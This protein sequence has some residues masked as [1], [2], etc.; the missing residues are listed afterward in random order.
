GSLVAIS[1]A[2]H[3]SAVPGVPRRFAL[4]GE[5]AFARALS[6]E[7]GRRVQAGEVTDRGPLAGGYRAM[8]AAGAS[9]LEPCRVKPVLA[10]A[11]GRRGEE[12]IAAYFVEILREDAGRAVGAD[13]LIHGTTGAVLRRRDLDHHAAFQYR[14]WADPVDGR[15]HDGPLED[16]TPHPTG[17]PDHIEL[18]GTAPSLVTMEGFNAFGDPWLPDDATVSTGNNVDAY[19]DRQSP[20]GFGAGD[21]RAEVTAPGVFDRAYDLTLGPLASPE[22]ARASVAH[23]FY[24]NN[25]L[26]D[27][28][29][30]SGF[31][32]AAG[33]AQMNNYGRGGLDGDPLLAEAQDNA[34]GGSRDNAN[35][36]TPSDGVSPRM[37]MYLWSADDPRS[38]TFDPPVQ[39]VSTGTAEFGPQT[40]DVSGPLLVTTPADGCAPVGDVSGGVALIDRGTCTFESKVMAAE[41]AGAVG[42]LIAN[43]VAGSAPGMADGEPGDPSIPVLSIS[44]EAGEAL[45]AALEDGAITARMQRAAGVER[46]SSLD[47]TIIA[48]EWGHYLHHRLQNCGT[49]MCGALS[50]G[51]GDFVALHTVVREGDDPGGVYAMS[52]YAGQ[53]SDDAAYFGIRRAPYTRDTSKNGFT[54]RHIARGEPL[55]QHPLY[56]L[57][58][59]N[60]EV[61]N[62]GEVWA[63]MLFEAYQALLDQTRGGAPRYSFDE[64]RRRMSDYVVAGLSLAPADSTFVEARD[65]ILAAAAASDPDD[66]VA[67]AAG[68]ATRGAGS[69]AVSP[70]RSSTDFVGVVE[71][72]AVSPRLALGEITLEVVGDVCDGDGLLDGEE[73]GVVRVV[74]GN[75]G[76]APLT[77]AA[78]EVATTTPGVSFPDGTTHPVPAIDPLSTATVDIPIAL[79]ATTGIADAEISVDVSAPDTCEES[80]GGELAVRV[81]YDVVPASS[82]TDDVEADVSV[83]TRAGNAA[84]LVWA[85]APL[86]QGNRAWHGADATSITDTQLVSPPFTVASSGPLEI[87]FRHRH[88]FET[89]SG[90]FW[91]GAVIEITSDGGATWEDVTAYGA[92]PPYGG[93][94]SSAA[95]NPLGGRQALVGRNPSFPNLDL[96][97]L[98]LGTSLA[99]ETVQVRFR[100]GT[101]VTVGAPG[102]DIDDIQLVNVVETPFATVVADPSCEEA[103]GLPDAGTGEADAG[104]GEP[105]AS[106]GEAEPDAGAIGPGPDAGGAGALIDDG[107]CGCRTGGSPAGSASSLALLALATLGLRRRRPR[108]SRAAARG[109]HSAGGS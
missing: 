103:G 29:Y 56:Q 107:G 104:P 58:S 45:R 51:W 76:P 21:L 77:G 12:L 23:L 1:G 8:S 86:G 102:W 19:T 93:A 15:P 26:H 6:N 44:Q 7:L 99:G 75:P 49:Y 94:L 2:V 13:Y 63:I 50:E 97:T 39:E 5:D 91:D 54:F 11:S 83:W 62:A 59:D 57:G 81:N 24:V 28:W 20:D 43:N 10:P 31:D 38:V 82:A 74:V 36:L 17:A 60:A 47:T 70:P 27:W 30:D 4:S 25:W 14:V 95:D 18:A 88:D 48:H 92:A 108:R 33:N 98:D 106:A 79:A 66:A 32:E 65:A 96:V 101:D 68:F 53:W 64:A 109:G 37:Q 42:V 105:D 84:D 85:R 52:T 78:I 69:C 61:H 89:S 100:I 67:M 3:P 80:D 90:T 16:A 73:S 41:A 55:P 40:F 34:L 35:M 87:R 46:D 71:D 9:L 72:F 22:Q